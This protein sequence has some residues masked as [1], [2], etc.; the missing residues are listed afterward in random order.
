[1]KPRTQGVDALKFPR[2]SFASV[3]SVV[4][5]VAVGSA[6]LKNPS[7][8]WASA[9]FSLTV[10]LLCVAVLISV[11]K[12]GRGRLGWLAFATFGWAY[13][14][15]TFWPSSSSHMVNPPPIIVSTWVSKG[16]DY[17]ETRFLT[18]VPPTGQPT[19]ATAAKGELRMTLTRL[20]M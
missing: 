8:L 11:A 14:A 5:L 12:T 3:M 19:Q 6:G 9:I 4:V 16:L 17:L 13:L 10:G 2:V 1:M 20:S 7:E 15:F 18:I